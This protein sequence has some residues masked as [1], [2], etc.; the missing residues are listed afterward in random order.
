[1]ITPSCAYYAITAAQFI[2]SGQTKDLETQ[3]VA[4]LA[5][6]L[7]RYWTFRDRRLD[8]PPPLSPHSPLPLLIH[9][10]RSV[11]VVENLPT[12]SPRGAYGLS[13][14]STLSS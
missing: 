9:R 10:L 2:I 14:A 13:C 11:G 1:M 4:R 3:V 5:P 6:Q 12:K 7:G 8:N